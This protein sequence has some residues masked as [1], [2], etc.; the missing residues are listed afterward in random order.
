MVRKRLD[1]TTLD[2]DCPLSDPAGAAGDSERVLAIYRIGRQLLEQ[3][4][5]HQVVETIQRAI[6]DHL[7][8][9][10]ACFLAVSSDGTYRP[11]TAHNLDLRRPLEAWKLSHTVLDRVRDEAVALLARDSEME[12]Q[13]GGAESVQRLRIQSVMCVPLGRR[14]VRGLLYADNRSLR[15]FSP[16][17]LDF[18]TAV[19]LYA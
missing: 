1:E 12:E 19:S 10:H 13:L 5:P 4:E 2:P 11:V 16:R 15:S 3:R 8:P 18:L 17:D 14:P 6:V 9:D 7:K